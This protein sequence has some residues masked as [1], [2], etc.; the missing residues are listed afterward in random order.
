[1]SVLIARDSMWGFLIF[2]FAIMYGKGWETLSGFNNPR[3]NWCK[4]NEFR[5]YLYHEGNYAYLWIK[6]LLLPVYSM[7]LLI[8]VIVSK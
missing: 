4:Y 8:K 3:I 2:I 7:Y 6:Y 5:W 1:M